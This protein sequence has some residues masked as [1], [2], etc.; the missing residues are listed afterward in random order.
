MCL[1][2]SSRTVKG[3]IFSSVFEYHQPLKSTVQTS[4]GLSATIRCW[5]I[6]PVSTFLRLLTPAYPARTKSFSTVLRAGIYFPLLVRL[7]TAR[8]FLAPHVSRSF[9]ILNN[10]TLTGSGILRL[11]LFG[12]L[13]CSL[14]PA[15]PSAKN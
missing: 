9:L 2:F 12:L 11:L 5:I 15:V 13:D 10:S 14:R 3:F 6:I 1:L 8:I 7:Y 4:L